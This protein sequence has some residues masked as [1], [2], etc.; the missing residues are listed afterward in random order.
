M[1]AITGN[2]TDDML[3]AVLK[4]VSNHFGIDLCSEVSIGVDLTKAAIMMMDLGEIKSAERFLRLVQRH[5]QQE[6]PCFCNNI[7]RQ[8]VDEGARDMCGKSL[9][10]LSA[11]SVFQPTRLR[12]AAHSLLRG[13]PSMGRLKDVLRSLPMV[14]SIE[15]GD[16]PPI[17]MMMF[18]AGLPP[19][20]KVVSAPSHIVE[21]RP[22]LNVYHC[23]P[24]FDCSDMF[25]RLAQRQDVFMDVEFVVQIAKNV[26]KFLNGDQ[27]KAVGL[28]GR[29]C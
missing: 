4:G 19:T 3:W 13:E 6:H 24:N 17:Y 29:F 20:V 21:A 5:K 8:Y 15:M 18:L 11:L 27:R 28:S 26:N 2:A 12:I 7:L 23:L 25:S 22:K 1:A 10:K 14:R 9:R 16:A